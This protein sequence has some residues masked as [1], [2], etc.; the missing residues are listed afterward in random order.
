MY[1]SQSTH[2]LQLVLFSKYE[3]SIKII[4]KTLEEN[5]AYTHYQLTTNMR[6]SKH[7]PYTSKRI[8]MFLINKVIFKVL[9]N[10]AHY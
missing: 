8:V 3:Q 1:E 4:F 9:E 2:P 6:V 10:V 5:V 7:V